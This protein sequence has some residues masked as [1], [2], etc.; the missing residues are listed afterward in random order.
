[1]REAAL[2][3]RSLIASLMEQALGKGTDNPVREVSMS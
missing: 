3:E 1:M 2:N